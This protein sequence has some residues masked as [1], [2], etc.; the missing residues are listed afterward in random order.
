MIQSYTK[1]SVADNTGAKEAA[2]IRT[3]GRG[4]SNSAQLGDILT[5]SIKSSSPRGLVK[6]GEVHRAV[7]VRQ[8]Y[9]FQAKNGTIIRFDEN[10]VVLI[11]NDKTPKGTRIFGPIADELRR[12]G[13]IKIVSMAEEVV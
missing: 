13:F 8:K 2:C 11:N 4:S 1:L 5:V 9:P 3:I 10:A 6:K 12:R 7:V